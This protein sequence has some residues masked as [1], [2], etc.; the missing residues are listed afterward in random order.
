MQIMQC[1]ISQIANSSLVIWQFWRRVVVGK[2]YLSRL[3]IFE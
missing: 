3:G 2:E 1:L